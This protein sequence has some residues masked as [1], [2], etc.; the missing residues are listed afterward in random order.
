MNEEKIKNIY[1]KYHVPKHVVSHMRQ[2]KKVS[3][4][5][6]KSFT[7]KKYKIDKENILN[8]A[9]LHDVLRICDFKKIDAENFH[10]KIT[11]KD[12]TVWKNLR[13]KYG[14][15]GHIK[16]MYEMLKKMGEMSLAILVKKHDFFAVNNLKTL[17]EKI[18]Y[19]SDKRVDRDKIVTLKHRF[20]E[21]RKRNLKSTN[22]K[23]LEKVRQTEKQILKL[24]K[25]FIRI[26]GRL[27]I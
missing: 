7:E 25:E 4:K 26:L 22:K 6:I 24:E 15:K 16:S 23:Y 18:L 13:Q 12:I 3:S 5:L 20:E 11:K 27:P 10:Q 1:K 8:A 19:Y 17:E 14:K 2:V 21:G 9:L